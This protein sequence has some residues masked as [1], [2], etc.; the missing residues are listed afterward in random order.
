MASAIRDP[1]WASYLAVGDQGSRAALLP[2]APNI[3]FLRQRVSL[4]TPSAFLETILDPGIVFLHR[5][6]GIASADPARVL[7][8]AIAAQE[9]G[10]TARRQVGGPAHGFW[11]CESGGAVRDVLVRSQTEIHAICAA[12]AIPCNEAEVYA[13]IVYNDLLAASVA[14]LRL[15]LDP[16]RLPAVGDQDGA[17][18]YYLRCWGPGKPRPADWSAN[19]EGAVMA[20]RGN[21]AEG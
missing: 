6:T 14:R 1:I 13:A 19:Y 21:G 16:A 7:M 5:I 3:L 15:W 10:L 11:Q 2:C 20:V 18:G 8:L 12:L 4:M 17:W 9:S